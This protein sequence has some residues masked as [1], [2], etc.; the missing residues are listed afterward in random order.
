MTEQLRF[1][2]GLETKLS[3]YGEVLE[4]RKQSLEIAR[5]RVLE[6]SRNVLK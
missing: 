4:D 5:Q 6:E 3:N 1:Y 2:A